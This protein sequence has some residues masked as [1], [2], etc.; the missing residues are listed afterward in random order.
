MNDPETFRE[1]LDTVFQ[2]DHDSGP[3]PLRLA[4][5]AD[6][7]VGGG[8]QQ[9]S[10]Y[11]HGAA[12]RILQQGM[13]SFRHDALGSLTL[14]IAPGIGSDA[15]RIVDQACFSG[16]GQARPVPC[17]TGSD[18]RFG[19]IPRRWAATSQSSRNPSGSIISSSRTTKGRGVSSHCG[20]RRARSIRS[21]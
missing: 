10:L 14:F 16:P 17:R 21:G 20:R 4:E 19:S 2:V 13:Y 6:E 15:Q 12:D 3:I 18:W 11:F 8:M 7:R 1:Q 5:V 9:F